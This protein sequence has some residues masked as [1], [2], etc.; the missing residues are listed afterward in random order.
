MPFKINYM[1]LELPYLIN[2]P[3]F[4]LKGL[5]G[6]KIP[7]LTKVYLLL[8]GKMVSLII[9]KTKGRMFCLF[10]NLLFKNDGDIKLIN[11]LYQKTLKNKKHI[12][13]PNKRI[14][15][16]LRDSDSHFERLLSSYSLDH[17]EF[18]D[19]DVVI[20]CGA[21]VG[22]LFLA[23]SQYNNN[24]KYY[25]FEPD[26]KAYEC[27]ILNTTKNSN[28]QNIGLSNKSESI[29]FYMDSM[30][31]NSSAVDFGENEKVTVP[32]EK[33]DNIKTENN[34][35]LLKVEAEGFEPEVLEGAVDTL[36]KVQYVAV[37]FGPERGYEQKDTIIE[38]NN[39][40]L[41]NNFQLIKFEINRITGL[42]VK[43]DR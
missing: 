13:F 24:L 25:A 36:K 23:L 35:K 42:Y 22:E 41:E 40:L 15:R 27:C 18:F 21:N 3:P 5:E 11:G 9:K 31:G 1:K 20:D 12:Y 32:V 4:M 7:F 28:I 39:F 14:L 8:K 37:D 19:G 10:M 26:K 43:V 38:V 34:I 6:K 30:G 16:V 29:D 33:L 17:I 2:I